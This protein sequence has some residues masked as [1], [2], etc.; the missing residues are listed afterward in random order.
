MEAVWLPHPFQT[1]QQFRGYKMNVM[2]MQNFF[3]Q[4]I[5]LCQPDKETAENKIKT[6]VSSWEI[7]RIFFIETPCIMVFKMVHMQG[8]YEYE[9]VY[10]LNTHGYI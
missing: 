2:V 6:P 1:L 4:T 7:L 8:V 3:L 9:Y 5:R 10:L